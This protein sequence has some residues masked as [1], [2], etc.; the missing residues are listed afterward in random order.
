MVRRRSPALRGWA[1]VA[2]HASKEIPSTQARALELARE[3]AA[4]GTRLVAETQTGGMGRE[5]R[6]WASPPGGVYLSIVLR[7]PPVGGALLSLAIG[8][9]LAIELRALT[10]AVLRLK[11]PND[12][13]A[14]RPGRSPGK[15]AGILVDTVQG[16]DGPR[17]VVGVGVNVASRRDDFPVALREGVAT[18]HELASRRISVPEA[19]EAVVRAVERALVSIASASG[20]AKVVRGVRARLYGRGGRVRLDGQEFGILE[21]INAD[22]TLAVLGPTGRREL[23]SGE[24]TIEEPA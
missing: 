2:R 21:G 24:V 13:V 5:G 12:L 10:G 7:P 22:G 9:E 20:R 8:S 1:T 19:E 23:R 6:S 4:P 15:V 18:L 14:P 3:G 17:T 16:V 11:W